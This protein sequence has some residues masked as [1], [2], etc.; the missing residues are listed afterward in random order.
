V[1]LNRTL[2][3]K[4]PTAKLNQVLGHL[5]ERNPPAAIGGK[6]FRVYYAT[7]TSTRPFRIKLFCNREE[8]LTEQYRRYLEAGVVEEFDLKGCPI[9]FDLVGKVKD[10]TRGSRGGG[11][12]SAE[13]REPRATS[14]WPRGLSA[15]RVSGDIRRRSSAPGEHRVRKIP[16]R[17]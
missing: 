14:A 7:Q 13:N 3:K 2:D 8:K 6:R 12:A 17:A 11:N 16:C 15:S 9:Y 1:K 5:A 10:E 4:M